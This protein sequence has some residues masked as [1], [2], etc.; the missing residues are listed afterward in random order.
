MANASHTRAT[1]AETS[2]DV[3]VFPGDSR[4]ESLRESWRLTG[5][6]RP[7]VVA[8]PR[9]GEE[10]VAVVDYAARVGLRIVV[11]GT[12]GAEPPLDGTLLLDLEAMTR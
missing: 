12:E 3:L 10:M 9:T 5:E 11:R 7:A 8:L 6:R 4:W 2:P 1:P